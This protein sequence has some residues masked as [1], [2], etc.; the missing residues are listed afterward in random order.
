[1][2]IFL[3]TEIVNA[4]TAVADPRPRVALFE[5]GVD[6][7]CVRAALEG[8]VARLG[9]IVAVPPAAHESNLKNLLMRDLAE[10]GVLPREAG[11]AVVP[12]PACGSNAAEAVL[13][14]LR[15][16]KNDAPAAQGEVYDLRY[17]VVLR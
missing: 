4:E 6:G 15:T 10:H 16:P 14:V 3:Q 17:E 7:E 2:K 5:T 1:M 12:G 8:I 9:V 13:K 11:E